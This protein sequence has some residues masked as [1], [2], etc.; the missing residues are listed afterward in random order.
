MTCCI[1][2]DLICKKEKNIIRIKAIVFLTGLLTFIQTGSQTFKNLIHPHQYPGPVLV[3]TCVLWNRSA[4]RWITMLPTERPVHVCCLM[5]FFFLFSFEDWSICIKQNP[6]DSCENRCFNFPLHVIQE[7]KR[8]EQ[9]L[10]SGD[11]LQPVICNLSLLGL[12]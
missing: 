9:M 11:D 5:A 4:N 2:S 6:K 12:R 8:S 10:L 7:I 1:I 3:W